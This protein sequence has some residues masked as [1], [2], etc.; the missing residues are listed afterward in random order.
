MGGGPGV[1]NQDAA[2]RPG[3]PQEALRA[4]RFASDFQHR[5]GHVVPAFAGHLRGQ[6]RLADGAVGVD[7]RVDETFRGRC[8]LQVRE[9][10]ADARRAVE[11]VQ[12]DW[13]DGAPVA[14]DAVGKDAVVVGVDR[15]RFREDQVHSYCSRPVQPVQQRGVDRAP[16]GPASQGVDAGVIDRHDQNGGVGGAAGRRYG[17]VIENLVETA[18]A[19]QRAQNRSQYR[20]RY[21]QPQ[22]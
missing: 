4:L 15:V 8:R 12:H 16:P 5:Y 17:A 13:Q 2:V 14:P 19:V 21:R 7:P 9:G 18:K 20:Q 3:A 6:Y 10:G 1:R 11:P 22:P